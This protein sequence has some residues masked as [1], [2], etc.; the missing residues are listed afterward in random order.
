MS[1]IAGNGHI[2]V[3]FKQINIGKAKD[4]P[5]RRTTLVGNC[6]RGCIVNQHRDGAIILANRQQAL[7]P[8]YYW[9]DVYAN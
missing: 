1:E 7:K 3:R 8:H 5:Y 2:G 6:K 4:L 9:S